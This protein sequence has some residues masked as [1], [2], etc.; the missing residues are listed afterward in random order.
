MEN[1]YIS[2]GLISALLL[3]T[4]SLGLIYNGL[5]YKSKLIIKPYEFISPLNNSISIRYN[6]K[7]CLYKVFPIRYKYLKYFDSYNRESYLKTFLQKDSVEDFLH[8]VLINTTDL[9]DYL[10]EYN[11]DVRKYKEELKSRVINL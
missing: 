1:L 7:Y 9:L 4:G 3:V 5:P 8:N 2:L 6:L 11:K 10:R